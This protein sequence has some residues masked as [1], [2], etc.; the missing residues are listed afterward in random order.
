M[1][2]TCAYIECDVTFEPRNGQHRYC[3]PEHGNR[4]YKATAQAAKR[5]R[6][7]PEPEPELTIADLLPDHDAI[8]QRQWA[9][10]IHGRGGVRV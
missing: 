4:Q 2:R 3:C 10:F 9:A 7:E 6:T 8:K 1:M 5:P